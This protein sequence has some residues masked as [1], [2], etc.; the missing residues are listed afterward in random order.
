MGEVFRN[1][2]ETVGMSDSK[3]RNRQTIPLA[4][5]PAGRNVELGTMYDVW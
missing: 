3:T 5:G 4:P 2:M 1:L